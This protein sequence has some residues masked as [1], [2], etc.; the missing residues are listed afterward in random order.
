MRKQPVTQP[1]H[2]RLKD[3]HHRQPKGQ[4]VERCHRL[5]HQHL[6]DHQ[7]KENRRYQPH[8][9]QEKRTDQHIAQ[10][11]AVL[12]QR[13][14]KP[15][16]IKRPF[17]AG[18]LFAACHQQ[19]APCKHLRRLFLAPHL[20]PL[21]I[22]ALHQITRVQALVLNLEQDYRIAANRLHQSRQRHLA[23]ICQRCRLNP[24]D[25]PKTFGN[26]A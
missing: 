3:Q 18:Y 20:G 1:R 24:R 12:H 16:N 13:R 21:G 23:D 4:N 17:V 2:Q 14:N 8:Q 5:V 25:K 9:L 10:W 19:Y 26:P 11:L 15:A 7:L 6:V 22:A